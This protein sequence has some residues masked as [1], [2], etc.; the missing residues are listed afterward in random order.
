[1]RHEPIYI[2]DRF[3][4]DLIWNRARTKVRVLGGPPTP[5]FRGGCGGGVPTHHTT[6]A[7]L[8]PGASS[9]VPERTLF[10]M[11]AHICARTANCW[12]EGT[13]ASDPKYHISIIHVSVQ[14]TRYLVYAFSKISIKVFVNWH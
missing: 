12:R 14:H 8:K 6:H 5:E 1:M 2:C 10:A 13:R 4:I 9:P 11:R 3:P 7:P